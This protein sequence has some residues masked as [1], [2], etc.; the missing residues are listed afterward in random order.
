MT[1][2]PRR[3]RERCAA[4]SSCAPSPTPSARRTS[5]RSSAAWTAA[6]WTA[7]GSDDSSP[8]Y[9]VDRRHLGLGLA[10][11]TPIRY[12]AMLTE[13]DG[14]TRDE[15]GARRSRSPAAARHRGRA[16]PAAG[17]RLRRLGPAPVG[18][19]GRPGRARPDRVGR[20]ARPRARSRT[21][22]RATRSR[23]V[24][25]T[26]PVN[27]IMH[28]PGGDSVPD[29]RE[30]GGD[31]SFVPID[32]PEIW[33]VQGDPTVYYQPAGDRV[34]AA[35]EGAVRRRAG[36]RRPVDHDVLGGRARARCRRGRRRAIRCTSRTWPSRSSERD[37]AAGGV[38]A[39]AQHDRAGPA[40]RPG[41]ER[42]ADVLRGPRRVTAASAQRPVERQP[43]Q[44]RRVGAAADHHGQLELPRQADVLA[45]RPVVDRDDGD[46]AL[47]QQHAQPQP[48]L[49]E[50]DDDD[51]VGAR[52]RAAAQQPGQVAAD[53]PLDEPA[54]ERGREQRA[55]RASR[56][57][58]DLVPLR[59]RP[60]RRGSGRR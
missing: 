16:L 23:C 45:V 33:L 13:P 3:G 51:V 29:T 5:S 60:G 56:S 59:A 43:A 28:L 19:R 26:K 39:R 25:D 30:P 49:A 37:L 11:G 53:Q 18:R 15:R 31:R 7:I 20:A 32:H 1:E 24:D 58:R 21:A 44:Q 6:T 14:T 9:A 35:L 47:A 27:F 22:G 2:A 48:D 8:A 10:P 36:G 41:G 40:P 42:D 34:G 55:R 50:A 46:A 52:H 12:R 57:R 54:G 38:A 17:R 4:A